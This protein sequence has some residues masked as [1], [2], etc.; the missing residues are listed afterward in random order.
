MDN[1]YQYYLNRGSKN[2]IR[3][4]IP[5]ETQQEKFQNT[6]PSRQPTQ[7]Q[8]EVKQK[9]CLNPIP[10]KERNFDYL[11]KNN[12]LSEYQTE[13]EKWEVLYNLGVVQKLDI[14]K[15]IIDAKV[16]QVGG[17]VWD[18]KP[19]LGNSDRVLSSDILYRTFIKY[20]DRDQVNELLQ[21]IQSGIVELA[22]HVDSA[23]SDVS[24]NPV[25]NKVI[26]NTISNLVT[27][28]ELQQVLNNTTIS[29][30][31][32]NRISELKNR[33]SELERK[34]QINHIVL[35]QSAYDSLDTYERNT[36]YIIAETTT[37][38]STFGDTFPFTL[39]GNG[40]FG[41]TFPITLN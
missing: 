10:S 8:E 19:T 14:L 33:I 21:N 4:N 2:F 1:N 25:Q 31:L 22:P 24:E 16:I 39:A 15:R 9:F 6:F 34:N 12:Y 32:E 37:G 23:L 11:L 29:Q 26:S 35:S 36:L 3:N 27:K 17:I 41:D 13:S 28:S 7:T 38:S 30:E 20:Y 40:T 5:N 18:D